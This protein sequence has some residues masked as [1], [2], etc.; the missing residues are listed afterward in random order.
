MY[1][2]SYVSAFLR[3]PNEEH[4][5]RSRAKEKRKIRREVR[6][7]ENKCKKERKEHQ[8][9][10]HPIC[11]PPTL[12]VSVFTQIK[13]W[14]AVAGILSQHMHTTRAST[15]SHRTHLLKYYIRGEHTHHTHYP[16]RMKNKQHV[17]LAR[18]SM[19][20]HFMFMA[21]S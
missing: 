8:C 9:N 17:Q 2:V 16:P 15:T 1:T 19:Y 13:N 20:I 4:S 3:S 18:I 6:C 21:H 10:A 7:G 5:V 14:R 12:C 11:H